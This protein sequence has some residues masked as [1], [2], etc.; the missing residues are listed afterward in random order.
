MTATTIQPIFKQILASK[1]AGEKLGADLVW[2]SIKQLFFGHWIQ[3][4][5]G[6]LILF[7]I[8]LVM[9][10]TGSKRLLG[11]LTYNALFI[12]SLVSIAQFLGP[13][14]FLNIYADLLLFA[15]YLICFRITGLILYR[16]R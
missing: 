7:S 12:V 6:A 13:A 1:E 8:A 4:A 14:T 3:I 9:Y 2:S 15:L 10:A 16:S 5:V 11:S